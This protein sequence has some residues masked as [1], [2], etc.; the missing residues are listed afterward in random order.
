M[1][2]SVQVKTND[3]LQFPGK[4]RGIGDFEGAEQVRLSP[5][6]RQTLPTVLSL[7]SRALAKER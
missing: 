4:P 3:I 5:C 7:K 1:L 6:A 2:G